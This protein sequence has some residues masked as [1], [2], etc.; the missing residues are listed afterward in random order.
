MSPPSTSFGCWF[1][2]ISECF[3]GKFLG[4]NPFHRKF[5]EAKPPNHQTQTLRQ[6]LDPFSC[7]RFQC[8][9][10]PDLKRIGQGVHAP[11]ADLAN[12]CKVSL[13]RRMYIYIR[14][15]ELSVCNTG[16]MLYKSLL[17]YSMHDALRK[18]HRFPHLGQHH[19][20]IP[21]QDPKCPRP[22]RKVRLFTC[23]SSC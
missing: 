6:I 5:L 15:K 4:Q 3:L 19:A 18:R 14:L 16:S 9:V 12:S 8:L 11:R 22:T 21:S 7:G 23:S 13:G 1:A 10:F 20:P 17:Y 2:T